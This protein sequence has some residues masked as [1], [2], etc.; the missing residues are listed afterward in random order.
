MNITGHHSTTAWCSVSSLPA[1]L[2]VHITP[3]TPNPTTPHTHSTPLNTTT[4]CAVSL[5]TPVG[6]DV[7]ESA[8]Q[9]G[10]DV[11]RLAKRR[12]TDA[13]HRLL[14]AEP[15][16]RRRAALFMQLWTL[17]EA[18]V[19]A[20]GIGISAHPGLTGF[21]IGF[22]DPGFSSSSSSSSGGGG[23]GPASQHQQAAHGLP[24][25]PHWRRITL[26]H[27]VPDAHGYGLL[28]LQPTPRHVSALC[29]QL[30]QR[31]GS[32]EAAGSDD[33][34]VS[35]SSGSFTSQTG[36]PPFGSTAGY[37][38]DGGGSFGAESSLSSLSSLDEEWSSSS[39]LGGGALAAAMRQKTATV[40]KAAAGGG[41]SVR[42][43][44]YLPLVGQESLGAA[45]DAQLLAAGDG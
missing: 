12:L 1:C 4:G 2:P 11:L 10:R 8:R 40:P 38:S 45:A 39:R 26:Q 18:F 34:A 20:K 15:D 29:V 27:H 32:A 5:D 3:T 33:P 21:S 14:A 30:P 41:W 31:E 44:R 42:M 36:Y 6:L 17:K 19:K 9:T 23:W 25:A 24:L 7:E 16:P 22:E 35:L 13:E 43:W 37:A 28:L